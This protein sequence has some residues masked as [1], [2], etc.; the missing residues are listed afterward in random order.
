M[1]CNRNPYTTFHQSCFLCVVS[2]EN[3]ATRWRNNVYYRVYRIFNI[4]KSY[5]VRAHTLYL[6]LQAQTTKC[7]FHFMRPVFCLLVLSL[8][9]RIFALKLCTRIIM[10][11]PILWMY[12][13]FVFIFASR[14]EFSCF[15]SIGSFV[16]CLFKLA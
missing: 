1:R 4:S 2:E 16:I 14:P 12:S 11:I 3:I 9:G 15:D 5:L 8:P 7:N 10:H 13:C 6:F